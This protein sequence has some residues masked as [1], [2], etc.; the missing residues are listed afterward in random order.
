M[1]FASAAVITIAPSD[2]SN[3]DFVVVNMTEVSSLSTI[4]NVSEFWLLL[5]L[6]SP[7]ETL[8]AVNITDSEGSSSVSALSVSVKAPLDSFARIV[9]VPAL[10]V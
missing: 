6:A 3:V 5:I 4:L 7:T 10:K 2:S 9:M 1:I 8:E